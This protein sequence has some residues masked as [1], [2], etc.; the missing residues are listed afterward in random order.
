LRRRNEKLKVVFC[1]VD[2]IIPMMKR[3]TSINVLVAAVIGAFCLSAAAEV[4]DNPYQIIIDR[5]PFALKP[6]PPPPP[7]AA[8]TNSTPPPPPVDVKLTGITTLLG[9]PKVF[10]E[11]INT[12]TKK[13]ERPSGMLVGE[14]QHDVEILAVDVL[15]NTV[16]IR[17]GDAETTLDFVN[18]GVKPAGGPT[19]GVPGVPAPHPGVAP[20]NPVPAPGGMTAAPNLSSGRAVVAGGVAPAPIVNPGQPNTVFAGGASGIPPRPLRADFGNNIVVAGGGQPANQAQQTP[21]PQIPTL[22][23]E[24][25]EARIEAQRRILEAREQAGQSAA[26][27][28]RILPPTRFS[29]PPPPTVPAPNMRTQ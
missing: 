3:G 11:I 22:S 4:K 1:A 8:E 26:G 24:E 16:R 7:A 18:N 9:P 5:N 12:Q 15:A 23:R 27:L 17:N 2:S 14:K 28:S 25:A 6:I 13:T 29:P 19:P 10:L 21:A 20:I